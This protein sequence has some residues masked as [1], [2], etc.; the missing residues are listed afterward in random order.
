MTM[1]M[2]MNSA[3][4]TVAMMLV[5]MVVTLR[6]LTP[7]FGMTLLAT[8]IDV[9]PF[10]TH[11]STLNPQPCSNQVQIVT[12]GAPSVDTAAVLQLGLA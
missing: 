1:N 9:Q 12:S 4:T 3:M 11:T 8:K 10:L 5:V 6:M 7:I 2:K